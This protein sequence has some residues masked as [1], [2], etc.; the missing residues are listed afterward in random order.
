MTT[1]ELRSIFRARF[2]AEPEVIASAPGRVNVI[3]EHTDYNGGQVLP[4]AID[5][6]TYVAMR[7]IP[8]AS[9][10]RVSS[11][12]ESRTGEFDA[13]SPARSGAWWDYM[14]G[15]CSEI[16]ADG[17]APPQFEAVVVSDVPVG[18]GLS[19][20]A[21]LEV[22]TGVA[23]TGLTK[24]QLDKKDL[25]L[26]GWRAENQFVGVNSGVMDQFA[27]ALCETRRAL[28]VWCDTLD[29]ESVPMAECVLIFDTATTRSLRG[30]QFN[31]RRAE[32]EEAL[33]L[34]RNK[35]P[36]LAN[37]AGSSVT[38]IEEADLP[39]LL[40]RRA[41]HVVEETGRVGTVVRELHTTGR[42]PGETLY[43]SHESLR[44]Q[45]ECS[46]P[47]LDWFVDRMRGSEGISGA[48]L[49]GAG[50]GGCAI[51]VGSP[52]A[53]GAVKDKTAADYEKKF[54]LR[55]RVWLTFAG[56]GARIEPT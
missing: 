35:F 49:T 29:T 22:A 31:S 13:R 44:T 18:A 33:A 20:S 27:S 39:E 26:V 45:Y 52:A 47:Q 19:S 30:S 10:S 21:A 34:L 40:A 56:D 23:L 15:V 51:A 28:H 7:A 55:P 43:Q 37:L 17:V 6:R 46:T 14:A 41:L 5:R 42:I 54:G 50:W 8:D 32:C 11:S 48:R 16:T 53:L 2:K 36:E 12:L 9:C 25:A 1:D 4:I 38:E 24:R 3:G